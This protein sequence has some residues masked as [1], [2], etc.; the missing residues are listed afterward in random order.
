MKSC[1]RCGKAY[2]DSET[3]CEDDGVA[4]AVA[5]GGPVRATTVMTGDMPRVAAAAEIECPVCGGKAQPGEV[6]CNFCGTRLANDSP[7][8]NPSAPPAKTRV[9]PENYVPA[10]DRPAVRDPHA[11]DDAIDDESSTDRGIIGILGFVIAA[12]LALAAGA[13]L[14]IYLSGRHTIAPVAQAS[15][16][17]AAVS[18]PTVTLAKSIAVQV[19]GSLTGESP[20]D[21]ATLTKVFNDNK[22]ALDG[23]Y[24]H[25]LEANPGLS[26]GMIMR[27]HVLPDGSVSDAS[28]RVSTAAN[29]SVDAEI[30]K[31][32]AIWKFD[33]STGAAVDVDYPV[34]LA[35]SAD[36]ASIES[37]LSS[38]VAALSPNQIPEYAMTPSSPAVVAASPAAPPTE[39]G[40]AAAPPSVGP[41]V[42]PEV[43]PAKPRKHHP[44][45]GD[46]ASL[47][48]RKPALIERLNDEF[49]MNRK[50]RRVQAYTSGGNVTLFGKV[51]DD[52]DKG[53]AEETARGVS[54]VTA[55]TDNLTTDTQDWAQTASRINQQLQGAGL[56]GVSAKVIGTSVYLSGT[57]KA[58]P[59]KERAVTIAQAAAPITVREN[60]IRVEPGSMF[61]F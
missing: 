41:E 61:G 58:Q 32:A 53:L 15:P 4:L 43:A 26:E 49:K 56:G 10:S 27:L 47:P 36:T 39:P 57:V 11:T 9:S 44:A 8:V 3:F 23:V 28:V 2:P 38:K 25:T 19:N 50:L 37:D 17:P 45:S 31:A 51:F 59:D 6:I 46:L 30:V 18:S 55:V 22:A 60:L 52:N 21:A 40:I 14:A 7:A 33:P 12:V 48:P 29:P 20:R 5:S 42:G 16:S 34:V 54:G 24:G 13:W 35:T 1:P